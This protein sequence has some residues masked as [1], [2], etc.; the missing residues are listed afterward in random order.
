M[1]RACFAEK[2]EGNK[3]V[4]YNIKI[5]VLMNFFRF[6]GKERV[7]SRKIITF[8]GGKTKYKEDDR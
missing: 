1:D 2:D 5:K 3:A 6:A 8:A 4:S 7:V